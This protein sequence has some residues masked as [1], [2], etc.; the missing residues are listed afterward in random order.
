[1]A[2]ALTCPPCDTPGAEVVAG[3]PV[4]G[5]WAMYFCQTCFYSWRNMEPAEATK[6]SSMSPKFR[7]DPAR[8]PLGLIMPLIPPLRRRDP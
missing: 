2:D 5:V 3:S 6:G 8:L 1:V 7:I 4:P